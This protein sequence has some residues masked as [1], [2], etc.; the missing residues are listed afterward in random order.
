MSAT[1]DAE[2]SLT[3]SAIVAPAMS[4]SHI[5]RIDGYSRTKG[6]GNGKFISSET[7]SVGGH[8]WCLKYCPDSH[9]S[10][11]SDWISVFLHLDDTTVD[12]VKATF[13]I[14]LLDKHGNCVP[15]F[16]K[17]SPLCSFSSC[18][19]T[20]GYEL[21][22][23][24]D[25]EGSIYLKDD[26]FTVRC[27]VTVAKEIFTKVLPISEVS[28][29][30]DWEEFFVLVLVVWIAVC[31]LLVFSRVCIFCWEMQRTV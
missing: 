15:S 20:K 5:L 11:D 21:I 4:G 1:S 16:S 31:S 29:R 30:N 9:C 22:K 10:E 8:R 17:S 2:P 7:F 19:C 13:K 14:S 25:L 6:L 3:A 28:R 26:V 24:S 12:E 18:Q 23:R 27:D